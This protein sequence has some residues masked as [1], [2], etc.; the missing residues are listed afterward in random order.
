MFLKEMQ[1]NRFKKT[2][3]SIY[4]MFEEDK[5]VKQCR[6][7][8]QTKPPKNLM[9]VGSSGVGERD[10]SSAVWTSECLWEQ[11]CRRDRPV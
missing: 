1:G 11:W 7:R 2:L 6:E 8:E 4:L 5:V 10:R 9:L 3:C